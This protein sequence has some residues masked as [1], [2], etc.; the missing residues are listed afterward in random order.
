MKTE[1]LPISIRS[2][3]AQSFE[4]GRIE[5]Q[6]WDQKERMWRAL[7]AA[8][9]TFCLAIASIFLP[10]AHFVLVPGFLGATF[11]VFNFILKRESLLTGG[12]G[13]CPCCHFPLQ[14]A[15]GPNRFPI[16]DICPKCRKAF[17]AEL[18]NS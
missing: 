12:S 17:E 8:G 16:S 5:I 2:E 4:T 14:F 1:N 18:L 10:L 13:S 11:F 7:K 3:F 15:R 9:L 6:S